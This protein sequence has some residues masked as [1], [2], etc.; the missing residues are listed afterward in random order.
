MSTAVVEEWRWGVDFSN[1]SQRVIAVQ[2]GG[3]AGVKYDMNW[4]GPL[5]LRDK[6]VAEDLLAWCGVVLDA[7]GG[8]VHLLPADG[9]AARELHDYIE[10]EE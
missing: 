9:D 1:G 4:I 6:S 8:Y 10:E 2:V 5:D 3:G 7:Y